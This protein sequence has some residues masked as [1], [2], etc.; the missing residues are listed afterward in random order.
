MLYYTGA[1]ITGAE[2][3]DAF[4]SLGG[5]ISS[6]VIPNGKTGTIFGI[7]NQK[8]IDARRVDCRCIAF[9]N[10][11]ER[12]VNFSI[13]VKGGDYSDMTVGLEKAFKTDTSLFLEKIEDSQS[14]PYTVEFLDTTEIASK[15]TL[16]PMQWVGIWIK[17]ELKDVKDEN[18]ELLLTSESTISPQDAEK[19]LKARE[20][21]SE[22][23]VMTVEIETD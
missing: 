7:F 16:E 1:E 17:R 10:R 14:L 13:K 20:K 21:L 9:Q 8:D 19:L 22:E 18:K 6:S 12:V 3:K 11:S 4:L 2:Q 5:Q 15:L 23:E